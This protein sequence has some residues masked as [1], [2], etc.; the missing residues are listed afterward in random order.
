M[1]KAIP[2]YDIINFFNRHKPF[3]QDDREDCLAHDEFLNYLVQSIEGW[4]TMSERREGVPASELIG[5]STITVHG[6]LF[7]HHISIDPENNRIQIIV[8]E[9]PSAGKHGVYYE[10]VPAS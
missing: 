8:C 4:Y 1:S 2:K 9:C 10:L 3:N 6:V 7:D 5:N